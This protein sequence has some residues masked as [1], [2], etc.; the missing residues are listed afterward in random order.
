MD[1]YLS[2]L[3][4]NFYSMK[5]LSV[6][7]LFLQLDYQLALQEILCSLPLSQFYTKRLTP[8]QT[9]LLICSLPIWFY[10]FLENKFVANGVRQD[11]NYQFTLFFNYLFNPE[12]GF[13]V[14]DIVYQAISAL[15]DKKEL[16]KKSFLRFQKNLETVFFPNRSLQYPLFGLQ[17]IFFNKSNLLKITRLLLNVYNPQFWNSL[18]PEYRFEFCQKI[19]SLTLQFGTYNYINSLLLPIKQQSD[20][21]VIL[22][23]DGSSFLIDFQSTRRFKS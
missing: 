2:R 13:V 18:K 14:E 7:N 3:S 4:Y 22:N 15:P 12:V 10:L 17:G 21:Q 1:I 6:F 19:I 23:L 11:R 9:E 8:A 5:N 16:F 20:T